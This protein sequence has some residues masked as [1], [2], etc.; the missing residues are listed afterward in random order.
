MSVR[1]KVIVVLLI[2]ALL[3]TVGLAYAFIQANNNTI[4]DR[5]LIIIFDKEVIGNGSTIELTVTQ[6]T[7][8]DIDFYLSRIIV[9]TPPDH[10]GIFDLKNITWSGNESV[11]NQ[12][13][14]AYEI[15]LNRT[16]T[17]DCWAV[18]DK[19][20]LSALGEKLAVGNW[21]I[22]IVYSPHGGTMAHVEQTID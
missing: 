2:I 9:T 5:F 14:D 19:I 7:D 6:L 22:D 18:G 11:Y 10:R 13:S 12:V 8:P 20:I 15:T 21:T 1:K 4:A 16:G 17:H 3:I